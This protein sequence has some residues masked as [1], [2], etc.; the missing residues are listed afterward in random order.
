MISTLSV[1]HFQVFWDFQFPDLDDLFLPV[2][3]TIDDEEAFLTE[4][5][6]SILERG[7][8]DQVPWMTGVNSA[9]GLFIAIR[10]ISHN[11]YL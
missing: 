2:V 9:E 7:D 11:K 5:P 10:K 4:H 6:T 1:S 8:Y 3:E